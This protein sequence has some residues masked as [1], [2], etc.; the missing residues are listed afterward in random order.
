MIEPTEAQI[1]ASR[2]KLMLL[3]LMPVVA[4]GLSTLVYFT[5]VGIPDGTTNRGTLLQPPVNVDA[6][7][8][9]DASGNRWAYPA[10]AEWT[11]I[12]LT[13]ADCNDAC[14]ETVWVTRQVRTGFGRDAERVQRVL[15]VPGT[16]LDPDF[17]TYLEQEHPGL[18]V[19]QVAQPAVT[20]WLGIASGVDPFAAGHVYLADPDGFVMMHYEPGQP[21]ADILKDMRFLLKYSREKNN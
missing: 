3:F 16:P 18:T 21:G 9:I 1:R 4:I 8:L 10:E 13:P 17:A 15:L 7:E 5:G 20:A 11:I 6:I 12:N 19:L 14:R 2:R